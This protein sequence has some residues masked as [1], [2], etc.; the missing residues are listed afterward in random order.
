MPLEHISAMILLSQGLRTSQRTVKYLCYKEQCEAS[1]LSSVTKYSKEHS[2]FWG[3][4]LPPFVLLVT[5]VS[6]WR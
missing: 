5:G 4:R 3:T 1:L 2:I 6:R